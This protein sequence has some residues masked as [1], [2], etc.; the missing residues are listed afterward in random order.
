MV[1][2]VNLA[3]SKFSESGK[4]SRTK[5]FI[6]KPELILNKNVSPWVLLNAVH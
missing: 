3:L 1:Y 2:L 4:G 5:G 6:N